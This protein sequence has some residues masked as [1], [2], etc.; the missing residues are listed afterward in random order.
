M[1]VDLKKFGLV[2]YKGAIIILS[3]LP[4]LLWFEKAVFKCKNVKMRI[5]IRYVQEW[6]ICMTTKGIIRYDNEK[7]SLPCSEQVQRAVLMSAVLPMFA[8]CLLKLEPA[9]RDK[10][11]NTGRYCKMRQQ[12]SN[13]LFTFF[14][15]VWM[16]CQI[17]LFHNFFSFWNLIRL[18]FS[19]KRFG[20]AREVQWSKHV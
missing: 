3:Y 19:T 6:L 4:L 8:D 14:R 5:W 17:C 12:A 11:H 20:M 1:T 15:N 10:E 16:K 9:M 7:Y 2:V 13:V 18:P